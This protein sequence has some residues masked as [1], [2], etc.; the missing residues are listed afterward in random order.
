MS[1]LLARL[2]VLTTRTIGMARGVRD[3]YDES[4]VSDTNMAEIADEL[5]R[6]GHDLRIVVRDNGLEAMTA[7][8][9]E[10]QD[11]PALTQPIRLS[12]PSRKNWVLEGFLI[13]NLR[14]VNEEITGILTED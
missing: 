3:H 5:K 13:E 4:L 2:A 11:M 1:S 7:P 10:T 14:L 6:S 8:H 9:P 12:R